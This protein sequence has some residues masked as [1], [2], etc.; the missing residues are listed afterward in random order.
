MRRRNASSRAVA[1]LRSIRTVRVE[2]AA[3]RQ[4]PSRRVG[5]GH[6]RSVCTDRLR[7]CRALAPSSP[8]H[9]PVDRAVRCPGFPATLGRGSPDFAMR[10]GSRGI[11]LSRGDAVRPKGGTRAELLPA[12]YTESWT[13]RHTS[14]SEDLPANQSF[15][16]QEQSAPTTRGVLPIFLE[17]CFR[18]RCKVNVKR[19]RQH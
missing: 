7:G 10:R 2:Q 6:V 14:R 19:V 12:R 18:T 3:C 15:N 8:M 13:S 16:H 4:R 17:R 1:S 11:G 5:M 9:P